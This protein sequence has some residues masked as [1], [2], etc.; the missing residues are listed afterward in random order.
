M[1]L[2]HNLLY[3]VPNK[4]SQVSQTFPIFRKILAGWDIFN[5]LVERR[6]TPK[7]LVTF[8][9]EVFPSFPLIIV[10]FVFPALVPLAE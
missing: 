8:R 2:C 9:A 5:M 3:S 10:K 1:V 4:V 6:K 7:F